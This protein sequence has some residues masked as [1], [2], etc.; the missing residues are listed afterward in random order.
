MRHGTA[1]VVTAALALLAGCSGGSPSHSSSPA[2]STATQRATRQ[3]APKATTPTWDTTPAS[4]AALGDSIT[5]G[6]DAC[7]ILKDCPDASWTKD[8]ATRLKAK[9]WNLARSGAT[10]AD[11][12]GQVRQAA[13]HK[14]AQV[15]ILMGANDACRAGTTDMTSVAEYRREF[16]AAMRTL[17]QLLPKA[18]VFVLSVPDLQRLWQV[19]KDNSLTRDVWNL[20]ICPSML[21][22]AD[23]MTPAAQ[24]RRTTVRDRVV[25]YNKVLAQVCGT[26]DRCRDDGGAV[27]DYRFTA[28]ELSP[29]DYFHPSTQ[30]Q[31]RL[32]RIAYEAFTSSRVTE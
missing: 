25:A 24:Q 29:W 26:Y 13:A 9:N 2:A 21:R 30:G 18:Q 8:L 6:F 4:L 1:V 7:G 27:F 15:T 11:L 14:P 31:S 20:G 5:R 10:M 32:A 17:H 16:T 12:D 28:A 3:A 19:G 22:D 23:S